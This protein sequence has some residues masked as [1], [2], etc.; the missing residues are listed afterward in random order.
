MCWLIFLLHVT[1]TFN[2][3][4]KTTTIVA[5]IRALVSQKRTVL[6]VSYTGTALENILLKYKNYNNDFVK[7]STSGRANDL[8]NDRT[9][10]EISKGICRIDELTKVYNQVCLQ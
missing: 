10:K 7:I 6:V 1:R 3:S 4:G 2:F 8:L 5:L 9:T